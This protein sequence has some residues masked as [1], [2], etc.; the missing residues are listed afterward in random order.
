M[1]R[2]KALMGVLGG[3][4]S[5]LALMAGMLAVVRIFRTAPVV[6]SAT[7]NVRLVVR[8]SIPNAQ[9]LVDGEPCGSGKCE[10]DVK[11]GG[12]RA[13]ARKPG[14]AGETREFTAKAG[15]QIELALQPLPA[16]IEVVSDL[17]RGELRLDNQAPVILGGG[18]AQIAGIE[19]GE[20]RLRFTSGAFQA[21]FKFEVVP[22]SPPRL[23]VPPAARGL[24]AIVVAG[25]GSLGRLWA[26]ESDAE[27][28][29]GPR[30]LGLI[31]E[32]GLALPALERGAHRFVLKSGKG[33]ELS[34]AYEIAENPTAWIWLR[35]Y[36][37]LGTL[38]IT[39]TGPDEAKVMLDG[40]DSGARI[41]RGRALLLAAPGLHDVNV[42]MAGFLT[43]AEQRA[44]VREGG[45]SD[46]DFKLE[47]VPSRALLS[48]S[49][50]P[51]GTVFSI[52]GKAVGTAGL[53]GAASVGD[54]DPGRRAVTAKHDG[55]VPGRWEVTLGAGRNAPLR[56][57]LVRAPGTLRLDLQPAGVEAKMTLRRLGEF[58][59][60]AVTDSTLQL[61]EGEYTVTVVDSKGVRTTV[62]VKVEAGKET[63]AT[64][65]LSVPPRPVAPPVSV[66]PPRQISLADW[67]GGPGWSRQGER[68]VREGG[69]IVLAPTRAS[70]QSLEF[71]VQV[72]KGRAVRW[73]TQFRDILN[74]TLYEFNSGSLNRIDVVAGKRIQRNRAPHAGGAGETVRI[75]MNQQS[76]AMHTSAYLGGQWVELDTAEAA[77][78]TGRFGFYLP[79]RDRLALSEFRYDY[80]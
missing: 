13:E 59:E 12:H 16:A 56:V 69:D 21:D 53:D 9:L 15:A 27:L 68:L 4:V 47:P 28:S 33:A 23:L 37:K 65:A 40:K 41:R 1:D 63:T 19:P 17:A 67:D 5:G 76:G 18:G 32:E 54:L 26:T 52:D 46:L 75:R 71:S 31:P 58:E 29:I 60:R 44:T 78:G 38:R 35:S 64:I 20:H 55:Y 77:N 73:V 36:R 39:T 51:P 6:A 8:S 2:G 72:P 25:A 10:I 80:R 61:A 43:P 30:E 79:G 66:S 70:A 22:G 74:Y 34:F 24:R 42:E 48:I 49:G 14:Y 11:P 50:A 62:Q 7:P 3:L 45:E 57:T